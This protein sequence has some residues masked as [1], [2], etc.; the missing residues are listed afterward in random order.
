MEEN[1]QMLTDLNHTVQTMLAAQE[2]RVDDHARQMASI[3]Q[4]NQTLANMQASQ[5]RRLDDHADQMA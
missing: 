1:L 3:H 2:A 4:T 5:D